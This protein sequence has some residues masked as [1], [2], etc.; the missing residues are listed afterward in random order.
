MHKLNPAGVLGYLGI[1]ASLVWSAL[2]IRKALKDIRSPDMPAR[3]KHMLKAALA[4][5]SV[6]LVVFFVVVAPLVIRL[7][8]LY[9]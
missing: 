3:T 8:P 7:I 1:I 6:M 4:V 2:G 9:Q 5:S